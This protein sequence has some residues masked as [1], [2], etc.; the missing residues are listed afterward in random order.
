MSSNLPKFLDDKPQKDNYIY[1]K[2]QYTTFEINKE[3]LK[4]TILNHKDYSKKIIALCGKWG[5]GKNTVVEML[6]KDYEEKDN[7]NIEDTE[8]QNNETIKKEEKIKIIDFDVWSDGEEQI[9]RSFLLNLHKQLGIKG[10]NY[11]PSEKS[12]LEKYIAGNVKIINVENKSQWKKSTKILAII[13]LLSVL[14]SATFK[15]VSFIGDIINSFNTFNYSKQYNFLNCIWTFIISSIFIIAFLFSIEKDE[16]AEDKKAEDKT[17][18]E[19]IKDIFNEIKKCIKNFPLKIKEFWDNMPKYIFP[20]INNSSDNTITDSTE[21]QSFDITGYEFREYYS[22]ILNRAKKNNIENLLIVIDNLDRLEADKIKNVI[23]NIQL[24]VKEEHSLNVWFLVLIDKS[25][26]FYNQDKQKKDNEKH[27]HNAEFF[28]KIFPIRLEITD[29]NNLDWRDFFDRKLKEA[30][31]DII[32]DNDIKT[33]TRW[34]Y[35]GLAENHGPRDIIYFIN[36]VVYNYIANIKAKIE[37]GYINKNFQAAVL[38]A[39]YSMFNTERGNKL[40]IIDWVKS[41]E[42]DIIKNEVNNQEDNKDKL[43]KTNISII[44]SKYYKG[45]IELFYKSYF[46]TDK[47][48][49]ILYKDKLKNYIENNEKN[50]IKNSQK[51]FP[52]DV[53]F[54]EVIEKAISIISDSL[55]EKKFKDISDIL[56]YIK[57]ELSIDIK[58]IL[59]DFIKDCGSLNKLEILNLENID[60]TIAELYIC[61]NSDC[62]EL[63]IFIKDIFFIDDTETNPKDKNKIIG[64]AKRIYLEVINKIKENELKK[65]FIENTELNYDIYSKYNTARAIFTK[66]LDNKEEK[67]VIDTLFQNKKLLEYIAEDLKSAIKTSDSYFTKQVYINNVYLREIVNSRLSTNEIKD[68]NIGICFITDCLNYFKLGDKNL[69]ELLKLIENINSLHT[70]EAHYPDLFTNIL[71]LLNRIITITKDNKDIDIKYAYSLLDK[72]NCNTNSEKN[73]VESLIQL[74]ELKNIGITR[75]L[76]EFIINKDNETNKYIFDSLKKMGFG[77]IINQL[78]KKENNN[79]HTFLKDICS[80]LNKNIN[81]TDEKDYKISKEDY[82]EVINNLL[83]NQTDK[84]QEYLL[85]IIKDI[86]YQLSDKTTESLCEYYKSIY[87]DLNMYSKAPDGIFKYLIKK[88]NLPCLDFEEFNFSEILINQIN[89]CKLEDYTEEYIQYKNKIF[90]KEAIKNINKKLMEVNITIELKSENI[91]NFIKTMNYIIEFNVE[92]FIQFIIEQVTKENQ[93]EAVYSVLINF[94]FKYKDKYKNEILKNMDILVQFLKKDGLNDTC[95]N[96]VQKLIS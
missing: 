13:V 6:K 63:N 88:T 28:E 46:Q 60:T 7:Q 30:F 62:E 12:D 29:I 41:L 94:L 59:K 49:E 54:L 51:D 64:N 82:T 91:D 50:E 66:L 79:S 15:F 73:Y 24:F 8:N 10:S 74:L 17:I 18:L 35:E 85:E 33:K 72:I 36:K 81:T 31:G 70:A 39:I 5:S 19:R 2:E 92:K 61:F 20:F 48:Y 71:K 76:T 69:T 23:D 40:S 89:A 38:N 93:F 77:K 52:N 25:K 96:K 68:L 80:Y 53:I 32:T 90:S 84:K 83:E 75:L 44:L 11:K 57:Y 65:K 27:I 37:D 26:F 14:F 87:K 21:T 47:P 55:N 86:D 9:K 56:L 42:Y 67:D 58:K 34:I 22:E 16:K 45:W 95:K 4:E 43:E 78:N 1:S 3:I